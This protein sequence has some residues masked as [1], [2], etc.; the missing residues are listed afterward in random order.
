MQLKAH[1]NKER[2]KHNIK[3]YSKNEIKNVIKDERN[4][5]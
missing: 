5:E 2:Q 1:K 3:I 4:E